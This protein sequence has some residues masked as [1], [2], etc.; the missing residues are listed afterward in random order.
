MKDL[1]YIT[2]YFLPL[3]AI[4]AL[5]WQGT[6]SWATVVLAFVVIPVA[7]LFLPQSAAN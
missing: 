5:Y 6:W 1:K 4:C 2:A 7:E 3:S